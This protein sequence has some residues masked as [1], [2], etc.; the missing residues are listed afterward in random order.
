MIRN[1]EDCCLWSKSY[2]IKIET[3]FF[4]FIQSKQEGFWGFGAH[5]KISFKVL[6]AIGPSERAFRYASD[7]KK[8]W[9]TSDKVM[10]AY[11]I[12][13][14][15]NSCY[16][17]LWIPFCFSSDIRLTDFAIIPSRREIKPI[18]KILLPYYG[19]SIN[20]AY[21]YRFLRAS[22]AKIVWLFSS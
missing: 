4:Y 20:W 8:K 6:W 14:W 15:H 18:S 22:I 3:L 12:A 19:L 7:T 5:C 2:G 16:R 17:L 21:T 13:R 10:Y 1:Q 11:S 9:Q